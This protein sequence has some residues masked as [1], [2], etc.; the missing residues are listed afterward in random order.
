MKVV[1]QSSQS[2]PRAS[3]EP[4]AEERARHEVTHLPYQP[5]RAWCVMRKVVRNRICS[6]YWRMR[7]FLSLRW[8]S[9]IFSKTLNGDISVVIR[10]GP[11]LL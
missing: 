6:D 8:T 3:D 1:P 7:K 11:E 5:L 9:V 4:S 2:V 10:H